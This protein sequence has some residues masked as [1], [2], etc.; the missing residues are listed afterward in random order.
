[1]KKYTHYFTLTYSIQSDDA[2]GQ[3]FNA[4][5]HVAHITQRV[6]DL[7]ENNEII[8]AVGVP[9]TEEN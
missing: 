1:M 2:E 9:D 5:A 3:D 8:E 6:V 7:Y 4:Q